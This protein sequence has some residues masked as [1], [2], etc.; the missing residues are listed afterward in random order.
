[1]PHILVAPLREKFA[2]DGLQCVNAGERLW[3]RVIPFHQLGSGAGAP[4]L[5]PTGDQPFRM[6]IAEVRLLSFQSGQQAFS[7][8]KLTKVAAQDGIDETRLGGETAMPGQFNG[9]M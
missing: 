9:L 8:S 1:M 2:G 3:R 5:E 6:G 4:P 7:G